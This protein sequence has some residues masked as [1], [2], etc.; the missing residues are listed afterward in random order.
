[1]TI[2]QASRDLDVRENLLRKWFRDVTADPV[3]AFP[4]HGQMKSEQAEIEWVVDF[5]DLWTAEG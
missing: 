2:A 3:H 5:T 4:G 1:V